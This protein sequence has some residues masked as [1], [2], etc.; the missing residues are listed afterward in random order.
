MQCDYVLEPRH[1]SNLS[2]TLALHNIL[3]ILGT[4]YRLEEYLVKRE[5]M[6]HKIV[7]FFSKTL[8]DQ[9][10]LMGQDQK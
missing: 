7:F 5:G 10:Q 9:H 2:K 4:R 6:L 8:P 3:H 1:I